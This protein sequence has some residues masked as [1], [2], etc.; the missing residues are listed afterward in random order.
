MADTDTAA[1]QAQT[2]EAAE[3]AAAQQAAA[4]TAAEQQTEQAA[5]QAETAKTE[6]K[7]AVE[8]EGKEQD[9]AQAAG[10]AE[11]Q[12]KK[13]TKEA[14]TKAPDAAALTGRL[15]DAELRAAAALA[16]VPAA[17]IPYA[18]RLADKDKAAGAED[19]SAYAAEQIKQIV[20]D[21]PELAAAVNGT[22]SA[23]DHA[24]KTETAEEAARRQFA[25]ALDQ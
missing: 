21:L 11:E 2:T 14:D 13:E 25:A 15:L 22:G 12:H 3:Q 9:K 16:G 20:Q 18:V 24:R 19:L 17:K 4:E 6:T 23:G 1:T 5:Q 10:A 7:A 8:G